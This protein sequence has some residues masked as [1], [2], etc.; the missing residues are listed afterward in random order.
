[1]QRLFA[2]EEMRLSRL[3]EGVI[4]QRLQE[5]VSVTPPEI[6]QGYVPLTEVWYLIKQS[7]ELGDTLEYDL[8]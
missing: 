6:P 1:M 4:V 3:A 8:R 2:L 7:V 5:C